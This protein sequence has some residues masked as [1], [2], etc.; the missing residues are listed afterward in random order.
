MLCGCKKAQASRLEATSQVHSAVHIMAGSALA[1]NIIQ[2]TSYCLKG[3]SDDKATLRAFASLSWPRLPSLAP[4]EQNST[5]GQGS[6]GVHEHESSRSMP[7]RLVSLS[8][9]SSWGL[10][11]KAV[12]ASR[13]SRRCSMPP[14]T[15]V[16]LHHRYCKQ[17]ACTRQNFPAEHRLRGKSF[18]IN[19]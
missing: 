8:D 1:L 13:L 3:C 15:R 6:A 14:V 19:C 17:N 5:V 9:R 18:E 11:E 10:G 7:Y 16:I 4:R 2:D 12:L